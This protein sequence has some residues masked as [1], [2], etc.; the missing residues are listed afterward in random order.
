MKVLGNS[1]NK[2]DIKFPFNNF[3]ISNYYLKSD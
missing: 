2:K 1:G 3:K